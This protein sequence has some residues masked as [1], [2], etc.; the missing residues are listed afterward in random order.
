MDEYSLL[1]KGAV[2]QERYEIRQKIGE[3]GFGL[4]YRGR[5]IQLGIPV[6]IKEYF[7]SGI[8]KRDIRNGASYDIFVQKGKEET[9]ECGLQQFAEE[10][11]H[12][13]S[14]G[15]QL[16]IASIRDYFTAN[17]TAYIVMDYVKGITMKEYCM[18]YGPMEAKQVL[19]VM[20]SVME[21]L[22]GMHKKGMLHRDVSPDNIIIDTANH[23][24]LVDFGSVKLLED[25]AMAETVVMIKRGFAPIEQYYS[26]RQQGPWTDVYGVC[27]SMYYMMT[28]HIP[29][30][31]LD[32]LQGS[33]IKNLEE[34]GVQHIPERA[35]H[36]IM[37]GL[38]V[39]EGERYLS[40][41]DLMAD[42]YPIEP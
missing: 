9:F 29:P 24:K 3:G 7:P 26:K 14:Y 13:V 31:V 34:W 12:L 41:A 8:A 35:K 38:S 21:I 39:S 5:D 22:Q 6:A 19:W 40:M 27:A 33:T 30:D 10:M 11:R 15:N 2:L 20:K 36:A 17:H 4:A 28:G 23:V 1:P 37:K 18:Q 32:R 16:G 42:L 25:G